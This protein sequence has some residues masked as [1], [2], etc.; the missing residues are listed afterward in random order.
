VRNGRNASL[1]DLQPSSEEL[2]PY[3]DRLMK[4][5]VDKSLDG[6]PLKIGSKTYTRGLGMHSR[7]VLTYDL[8]GRF[9]RFESDVG[10]QDEV[11]Q[12]GNVICRVLTDGEVAFEKADLT[13][14]SGIQTLSIDVTAKKTLTLE[15]DFG[16][17]F[18]VGDHVSWGD[19]QL[20]QSQP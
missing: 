5:T 9:S 7:T 14:A 1:A 2:T 10:L 6:R 17:N 16:E 20:K 8:D 4:W 12:S 13:T 15:V 11:G 18:D 3:F 19:P